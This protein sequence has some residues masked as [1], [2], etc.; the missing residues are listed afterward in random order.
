MPSKFEIPTDLPPISAELG[1]HVAEFMR[2][3][4]EEYNRRH[5]IHTV[6]DGV[7]FVT[8][9]ETME[10]L[11]N[12]FEQFGTYAGMK[13]MVPKKTTDGQQAGE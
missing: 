12:H 1:K 6:C 13:I 4:W 2:L 8:K 5:G 3:Y 11:K 9:P 7:F 10:A